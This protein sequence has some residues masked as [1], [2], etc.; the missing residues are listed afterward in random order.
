MIRIGELAAQAGVSTRALRYYE[1]HGLLPAAR[2]TNGQRYYPEAAVHR[3][4]LIKSLFAAGLGS[5]HL[6]VLLPLIDAQ[7]PS[8]EA[9]ALLRTERA[10]IDQ[11]IQEL[12]TTRDRLD[13]AIHAAVTPGS[14]TSSMFAPYPEPDRAA[15]TLVIRQPED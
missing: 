12:T 5:R 14:C 2:S 7:Q 4:A 9:V 1:E 6:T 3:V 10:Q 11:Q 8:D 15:R 13:E